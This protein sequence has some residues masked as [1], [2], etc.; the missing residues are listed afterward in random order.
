[1]CHKYNNITH[2]IIIKSPYNDY[3][4]HDLLVPALTKD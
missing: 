4:N 3:M 2:E 1:M